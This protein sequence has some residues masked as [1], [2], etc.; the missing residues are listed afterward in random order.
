MAAETRQ[1]TGRTAAPARTA[2]SAK[3]APAKAAAR[4]AAPSE[5]AVSEAAAPKARNVVPRRVRP[6]N[7]AVPASADGGMPAST[8]PIRDDDIRME[9]YLL[10]LNAGRPD[11]MDQAHW[12]EAERRLRARHASADPVMSAAA[13]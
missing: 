2:A 11:G 5:V 4:K 13:E 9:A 3:A 12:F 6:A 10:W 8:A 7:A 1:R